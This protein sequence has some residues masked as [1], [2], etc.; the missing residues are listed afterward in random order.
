MDDGVTNGLTSTLSKKAYTLVFG[1]NPIPVTLIF[2][3]RTKGIN[4]LDIILDP[5]D[6]SSTCSTILLLIPVLVKSVLTVLV[7]STKV[8]TLPLLLLKATPTVSV[9]ITPVH[10]VSQEFQTVPSL[11]WFAAKTEEKLPSTLTIN[12]GATSVS[13]HSSPDGDNTTWPT[14]EYLL[15]GWTFSNVVANEFCA[16]TLFVYG[17][18]IKSPVFW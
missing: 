1:L 9:A 7:T 18:V 13:N 2:L 12:A 4:A 15:S 6:S 11:F 17:S 10:W 8:D 16:I 14:Q 3:G 5:C